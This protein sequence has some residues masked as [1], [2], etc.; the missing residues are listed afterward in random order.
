MGRER[1]LAR[2]LLDH[3]LKVRRGEYVR[4]CDRVRN[5]S[6]VKEIFREALKRG[7]TP[8]LSSRIADH[9]GSFYERLFERWGIVEGLPDADLTLPERSYDPTILLTDST[10][11]RRS[12]EEKRYR[13]VLVSYPTRRAERDSGIPLPELENT[14][15][16][17]SLISWEEQ[18]ENQE[19]VKRLFDEG[20][21]VRIVG[22]D[23]DLFLKIEGEGN[24][25]CGETNMPDGEI[26]YNPAS[27]SVQGKVR[28]EMVVHEG[29]VTRDVKLEF[30][31]GKVVR[32]WVGKDEVI[33]GSL[34]EPDY[35]VRE[36]GIGANPRIEK[37]TSVVGIDEKMLGTIHL[38]LER[39]TERKGVKVH[40]DI[41]K[42]LRRGKIYVDGELVQENGVFLL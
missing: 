27:G 2:L 11:G 8:Y 28:F 38:G 18:R 13:A 24:N 4:I 17:A 7:V 34:F 33:F 9:Y 40:W 23:T 42:D 36:F 41:V 26:F 6:L 21:E 3:S 25:M 20:D 10:V 31:R 1:E 32:C 5:E 39:E 35:E 16:R 30:R 19:E 37:F 14:F 22:K 29:G 12:T 15:Y